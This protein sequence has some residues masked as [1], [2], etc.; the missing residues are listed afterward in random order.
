M[1][2]IPS[3]RST[4]KRILYS[5]GYKPASVLENGTSRA[6]VPGM[7]SS[8]EMAFFSK[9]AA[10]YVGKEGAILDLGCWLGSTSIS[11][12]QGILSHG[13]NA[14]NRSEKVL[15]FDRFV[16]EEW[17]PAHVPHCLYHCGDSFLP[18]ARRIVR[19]HGGGLV[20]LI[21][22]DLTLYEWNGGPIKILLVDA[23]K[24]EAI[25]CQITRTFYPS[26][27]TG[28]LLIHQDFKHY[29]TSWIHVFQ[30]RLRQYFRLYRNLLRTG[31]V[32]F[33]V[34]AP[35]PRTAVDQATDF[36]T[37]PDDE[38]DASFRHSLDLV[39]SAEGVNIAAAHV[40]HYVHLRRKDRASEVLETYRSFGTSEKGEFPKA[41][42]YLNK[43]A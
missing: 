31:T 40:M 22:A 13:P 34:L 8:D 41:L 1:R 11:L 2:K 3:L 39:G 7:V 32:A 29:Y 4:A 27:T 16:W 33:E 23:M 19:D 28:S 42:N 14:A 18:E 25:A 43:M 24:N 38:I 9:S 20:E 15:G 26:L 10:R 12:A 36:G 30:Y 5:M 35:I 6:D 17:M 21:Q 37:I